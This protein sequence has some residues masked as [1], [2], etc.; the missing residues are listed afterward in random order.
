MWE[1]INP[2]PILFPLG[3]KATYRAYSSDTVVQFARKEPEQCV[4]YLGRLTGMEPYTM[5]LRLY[6]S[7]DT[8]NNSQT[9]R[10][11]SGIEG[12]YLLQSLPLINLA[13][14]EPIPASS[15]APLCAQKCYE[16]LTEIKEKFR[17]KPLIINAWNEWYERYAPHSDSV[18]DYIIPLQ[19][20]QLPFQVPLQAYMRNKCFI[21]TCLYWDK[22]YIDTYNEEI[23]PG[24]QWPA[25][26]AAAMP[27]VVTQFDR[28]P[29]QPRL[30]AVEH[31]QLQSLLAQYHNA[32]QAFYSD[33]R[34]T[35]AKLSK[36]LSSKVDLAGKAFALSGN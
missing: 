6:P 8:Y 28:H 12:F 29:P 36:Y 26:L 32:T 5:K 15:F 14:G 17:H 21:N 1:A 33:K 31:V 11:R 25:L 7:K 30:F 34:V 35:S 4:T 27:S 18:Q 16:C 3:V 19:K 10:E 9:H 22:P 13:V 24:F 23:D 20:K 2:D